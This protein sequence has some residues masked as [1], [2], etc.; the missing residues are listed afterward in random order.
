MDFDEE[1][2]NKSGNRPFE[3]VLNASPSR[4]K[5]MRGSLAA[6]AGSFLAPSLAMSREGNNGEVQRADE[7]ALSPFE[8]T[9]TAIEFNPVPVA[10]GTGPTPSVSSDYEYQVLIPWGTPLE[11]GIEEYTGDPNT[12]PTSQ[13]QA[14]MVGIGHDGMH[15]FPREGKAV[16]RRGLLAINHE[17][18]LNSI[19]L[20]P[21]QKEVIGGRTLPNSLE[22]VRLSQHAHGVSIVDIRKQSDGTW[23]VVTRSKLNRRIHVNTPVTFSGPAAGSALLASGG[24]ALG[25]VNNCSNGYTPWGTYLTGEENTNAYFG[26]STYDVESKTGSWEPTPEQERYGFTPTGFNYGWEVWDSRFDLS[27]PG[28]EQE[29]NRFGWVVEIDP[30]NPNSTPVKRTALGRIKHEGATI[31]VG[32][33]GRAVCYMGDDQMF[34][35]VYKFVSDDN[36][37]AMIDSGI[38]PLDEGCLYVARFNEDGTGDWLELTIDDPVIQAAGFSSQAEVVTYA[39]LA[40]DALGATPMDR[41]E[42]ISVAPNRDVF[43]TL[44]N[45]VLRGRGDAPG[46]DAVNP[47][48]PNNDGHIIRWRDTQNHVGTRFEWSIFVI[49]EN[50]HGEEDERT[51]SDPDGLWIDPNGRMFILTDGGQQKGLN[52]QLLVASVY[53]DPKDLDIRRLFTGVTGD[54]ITGITVTD[55]RRFMFV[56]IQH[57]GNG[58]PGVTN[59]PAPQDG[60]TLPRDCTIVIKRKDKGVVGS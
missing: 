29:A 9:S 34:D 25:T 36:W 27:Q 53:D 42:W 23:E 55:N 37:Q 35:Y 3:E 43:C 59:F 20:A 47:L 33:G 30:N 31:A 16:N 46:A 28:T 57:P 13:E 21:D 1:S 14:A 44:S 38:S 5:F 2:S 6:A 17:F 24:P 60:T 40:A 58:N 51:F 50:T 54:E 18:G 26:D 52:N 48:A 56:N 41:P 12:R 19:V 49:A 7:R 39:R 8:Q 45:N 15:F 11:P 10:D 4:R 32:K 22:A